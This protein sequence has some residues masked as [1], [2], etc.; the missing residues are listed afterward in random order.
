[1][2]GGDG[3]QVREVGGDGGR[4]GDG[5]KGNLGPN[6]RTGD[7]YTQEQYQVGGVDGD[8][9]AIELAEIPGEGQDAVPGYGKGDPL[10]GHETAGGSTCRVD[11]QEDEDGYRT[12]LAHQLD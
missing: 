1:M 10:R 9:V 11:P 3:D 7:G 6:Y 2:S 4:G 5:T 12:V 8:P